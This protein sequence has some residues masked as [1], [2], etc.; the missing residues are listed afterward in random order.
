[1]SWFNAVCLVA[2]LFSM[3][4][5][6]VRA[7]KGPPAFDRILAVN[8]FG[9]KTVLLIVVLGFASGRPDFLDIA[10]VYAMMNFIS[11]IAVLRFS[12]FGDLT[13]VEDEPTLHSEDDLPSRSR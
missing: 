6:L 4:L 13:R 7:I 5:L 8:S 1:L 3:T 12:R 10:L 9:T 2:I 11:T